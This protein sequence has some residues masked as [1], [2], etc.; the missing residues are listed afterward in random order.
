[1]IKGQGLII[2]QSQL[3]S[4]ED[5]AN[6]ETTTVDLQKQPPQA[7]SKKQKYVINI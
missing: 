7:E 3:R 4:C 5:S 2:A 6:T 1:M